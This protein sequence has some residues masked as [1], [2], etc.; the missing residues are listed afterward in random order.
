[1][2]ILVISLTTDVIGI[3][4]RNVIAAILKRLAH[5]T[6]NVQLFALSLVEALQKNCGIEV[7]REMASK[8]F[9]QG[10]EKLI[11]DRVSCCFSLFSANYFRG[12]EEFDPH[13]EHSR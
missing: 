13:V 7:H 4:A 5:R 8:S 11:T 6:S 2:L 9:T 10:M 3:R 12:A 1:M